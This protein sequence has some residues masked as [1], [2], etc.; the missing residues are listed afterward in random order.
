MHNAMHALK[1]DVDTFYEYLHLLTTQRLTLLLLHL[2]F[3]AQC[4]TM[5]KRRLDL[6]LTYA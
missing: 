6:M 5:F 2:T 1:D 4:Y 3:Y